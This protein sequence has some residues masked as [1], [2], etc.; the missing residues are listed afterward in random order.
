MISLK[1][2]KKSNTSGQI[3]SVDVTGESGSDVAKEVVSSCMPLTSEGGSHL[4]FSLCKYKWR[5]N[6][7]SLMGKALII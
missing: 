6:F 5:T 1:G 7:F 2:R 3:H 4:R